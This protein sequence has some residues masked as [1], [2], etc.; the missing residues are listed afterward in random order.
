MKLLSIIIPAYNVSEYINECIDS[1]ICNSYMDYLDIIVINDGSKDDTL[2]KAIEYERRFPTSIRVIDK[3]NGGHGSGINIG[4]K[5]AVGKYLK[6]LDSDDWFLNDGLE[7]LIEY[8]L[9]S[10]FNPDI[11]I[12]AYDQ[13]WE[14]TNVKKNHRLDM[15]EKNKVVSLKDLND[16]NYRFTIHSLTIKTSIYKNC[17]NIQIDEKTVYDDVQ[18]VLYPVQFIETVVYL[19]DVIYQYRMGTLN[20]SV[21]ITNMQ[22]NRDKLLNIIKN[23]YQYYLNNCGEMD[24]FQKEYFLRDLGCTVGDYLNLLFTIENK[25]YAKEEFKSF[26]KE[27][28]YPLKYIASKKAVFSIY[29][30]CI[31]WNVLSGWYQKQLRLRY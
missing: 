25:K 7:K 9:E 2:E 15:L 4:V 27:I 31:L 11:I 8:I 23:T 29:T 10:K 21:N 26:Y 28:K 19:D 12:N 14:N 24:E 3:E 20:Q 5:L 30:K 13:I 6:V 22:R 16:C 1:I 18:Y 17:V